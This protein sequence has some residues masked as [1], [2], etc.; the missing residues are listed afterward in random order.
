[1]FI[2]K[3]AL[4]EAIHKIFIGIATV[5]DQRN[6]LQPLFTTETLKIRLKK[7]NILNKKT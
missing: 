1:M 7:T 6:Y 5:T 4:G 2:G 3:Q